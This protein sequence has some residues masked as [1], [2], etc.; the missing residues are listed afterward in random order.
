MTN[1]ELW[2]ISWSIFEI[3]R[4]GRLNPSISF[5]II[6]RMF[7]SWTLIGMGVT[8][9]GALLMMLLA[10]IGQSPR[11]LLRFIDRKLLSLWLNH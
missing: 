3:G 2:F 6:P 7:P 8:F 1:L 5:V 10:Y 9:L 4:L 11:V